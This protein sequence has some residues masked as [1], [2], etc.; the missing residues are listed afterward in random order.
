VVLETVVERAFHLVSRSVDLAA[1]PICLG[2]GSWRRQIA[3]LL[4]LESGAR[5]G[6][7]VS[8]D[9]PSPSFGRTPS[10]WRHHII[11]SCSPTWELDLGHIAIRLSRSV[12]DV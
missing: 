7:A 2:S 3:F 9:A 5:G 10:R 4:Q 8:R 12:V 6:P 11:I 1:N